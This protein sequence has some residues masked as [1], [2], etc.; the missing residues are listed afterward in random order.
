M[1]FFIEASE[2][3]K[4]IQKIWRKLDTN[5]K[6]TYVNKS[7]QNRYKKKSDDK[8]NG[9]TTA[10][11]INTLRN[12]STSLSLSSGNLKSP[13][14]SDKQNSDIENFNSRS[15]TPFVSLEENSEN[16][17]AHQQQQ[18]QFNLV[19]SNVSISNNNNN[20]NEKSKTDHATIAPPPPSALLISPQ[21]QQQLQK[22][23]PNQILI[24]QL[25]QGD[26]D[27]S[28][29]ASISYGN[30]NSVEFI[31]INSNNE[32]KNLQQQQQSQN[33]NQNIIY[34]QVTFLNPSN[35]TNS[36]SHLNKTT[37]SNENQASS[38][39][40]LPH[41]NFQISNADT[42]QHHVLPVSNSNSQ[43]SKNSFVE[44]RVTIYNQFFIYNLKIF[45]YL[46]LITIRMQA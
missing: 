15:T 33:Q 31:S 46:V 21:Q 26:K 38:F 45:S 25:N 13:T 5:Q 29:K 24:Y 11:R 18:R 37:S 10:V 35:N 22:Q 36:T 1:N 14:N 30:G 9:G 23:N 17:L 4:Y 32:N 19:S 3:Y 16:N 43:E 8:A 7:R 28:Q 20:N 44:K 41:Q 42:I 27:Q 12:N 39:I 6:Q 34:E 2:R 40:T